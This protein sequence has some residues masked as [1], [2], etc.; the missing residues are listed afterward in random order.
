MRAQ[1]L[2]VRGCCVCVCLCLRVFASGDVVVLAKQ[3]HGRL[4]LRVDAGRVVAT[5]LEGRD[6]KCVPALGVS[7]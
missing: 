5:N 6:I 7:E 3:P 4:S 1:V 2:G